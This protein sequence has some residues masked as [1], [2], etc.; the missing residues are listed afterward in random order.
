MS[1]YFDEIDVRCLAQ[2]RVNREA[3]TTWLEVLG[4]DEFIL[5]PEDQ[6]ADPALLVALAAK[7]CYMS[8]QPGMNPNVTKIRQ[9][10]VEYL[11]NILKQ[12][13]GSVLEHAVFTFGVNGCS[14]VFTAEMNRHRA[15]VAI[16]ERSMRYIRYDTI[17]YWMPECFRPAEGDSDETLAKKLQSRIVLNETFN[18]QERAMGKFTRIWADELA[19]GPFH[20]KKTLT[21]AFRRPI[22]MGIATGGIWTMNVR[23]LR[24]I[25]ALRTDEG[26]EEE[27]IHICRKIGLYMME[28]LPELF[29]DFKDNGKSLIPSFWKV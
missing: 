24:H 17:H 4:A 10:M 15:G 19:N 26:A 13:H 8:F 14:R 5:P 9:D 11:D 12:R 3:V 16:S 29:S 6:V 18:E 25:I 28:E 2:T 22:G 7:Q 1:A 27:A 23:S 21:S 20:Q